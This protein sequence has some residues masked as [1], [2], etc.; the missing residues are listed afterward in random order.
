M[1]LRKT[2]K[3]AV[4]DK[5]VFFV[6]RQA[7]GDDLTLT[8]LFLLVL[9]VRTTQRKVMTSG[10]R[11]TCSLKW[12]RSWAGGRLPPRLALLPH[13]RRTF[14]SHSLR[15]ELR[16]LNLVLSPV[17]SRRHHIALSRS[18]RVIHWP[19]LASLR[20]TTW[21]QASSIHAFS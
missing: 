11:W 19:A 7:R 14:P 18:V 16:P 15:R 2:N 17:A 9:Q 10:P 12:I 13:P 1:S 20:G 6:Y 3:T 8:A 21:R 5:E 4:Y